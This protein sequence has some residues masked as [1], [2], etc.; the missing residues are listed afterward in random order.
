MDIEIEFA[1]TLAAVRELSEHCT[2]RPS[3]FKLRCV[4][5]RE[6]VCKPFN[7]CA[8]RINAKIETHLLLQQMSREHVPR[9]SKPAVSQVS[10]PAA[11]ATNAI[12]A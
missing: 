3:P 7:A 1:R 6:R 9:T 10:K 11:P 5:V 8:G 12:P 2:L 4:P